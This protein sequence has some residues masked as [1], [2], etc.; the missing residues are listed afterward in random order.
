MK[1]VDTYY[2][3]LGVARSVPSEV[4][5]A[6]Y[7]AL[8]QK[9][10]PDKNPDNPNAV[11]AMII[12]NVSFLVLSDPIKRR[13]YDQ[14]LAKQEQETPA[15][16]APPLSRTRSFKISANTFSNFFMIGFFILFL[17][18]V[19]SKN[20]S[21]PPSPPPYQQKFDPI[22]KFEYP[23]SSQ[24]EPESYSRPAKAPNGQ[25]WPNTSDYI[26]GYDQLNS[27]G[28]STVTVDNSKNDSDVFV[29]W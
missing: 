13:Q 9:Y 28:L 18:I 20:S 6:A 8:S 14:Y 22:K 25:P 16:T 2:D 4:I 7:K 21:P 17:S 26:K 15:F 19:F 11:Q 10:H 1:Q 3:Y 12:I 27:I 24:E 29:N 5:R 23:S